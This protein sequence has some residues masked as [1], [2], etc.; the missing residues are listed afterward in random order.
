[1]RQAVVHIGLPRT[2]TTT[3]QR[4][5]SDLRPRLLAAGILYPDLTPNAA[6]VSHLSHQHLGHAL[7]GRC[8][9]RERAELL[10]TLDDQLS[11]TTADLVVLSYEAL[12]LIPTR[13][14]APKIL[15]RILARHGFTGSVVATIKPQAEFLNSSYTWRM[16]FL[17]E[18]RSF[19][20]YV[21]AEAGSRPLDFA[22]LFGPWRAAFEDRLTV[23]PMRD[24]QSPAVPFLTRALTALGVLPRAREMV[25]REDLTIVENRSPGPIAVEAARR[26]RL[27]AAHGTLRSRAREVTRFMEDE[28]RARGLD[29]VPF[30]GLDPA[31]RAA[32]DARWQAANERLA[33]QTWDTSFNARVMCAPMREI[34]EVGRCHDTGQ[35]DQAQALV[36][37]ACTTFG[38][39]MPSRPS[40]ALRRL[41]DGLI[42]KIEGWRSRL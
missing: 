2:G 12:C 25:T 42:W 21:A 38:L 14:E 4:V 40:V 23:A 33:Q 9:A 36:D 5:L 15:A 10:Q 24:K 30:N 32:I 11:A 22:R 3:I 16:Q 31:T 18:A 29:G 35:S 20:A 27:Q 39:S 17:R 28:A 8:P 1:M 41:A 26:L 7:S 19:P 6:A 13:W 34:N 37:A